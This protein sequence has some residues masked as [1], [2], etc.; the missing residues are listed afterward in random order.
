MV[1]DT[2]KLARA[3]RAKRGHIGL[4]ATAEQIGGVSA[5][6]LSRV[7]Q[8]KVP[9]LE[10]FLRLCS[11]LEMKP[12]EFVA[13]EADESTKDESGWRKMAFHLRADRVLDQETIDALT[14]MIRLAYEAV[15]RGDFNNK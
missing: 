12:N 1:V 7:E 14:K 15:E 3:V 13:G 8:G 9:D 6:T 10:T 4:R 2:E 5:A 11:W